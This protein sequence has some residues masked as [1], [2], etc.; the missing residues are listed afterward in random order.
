VVLFFLIIPVQ[1]P[2]HELYFDLAPITNA[3]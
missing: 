1:L 3:H 2:L